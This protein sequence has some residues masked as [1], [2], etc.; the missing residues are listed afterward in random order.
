[1]EYTRNGYNT[2]NIP[3]GK[4]LPELGNAMQGVGY[5]RFKY[6][7]PKPPKGTQHKYY[8]NIYILDCELTIKNSRKKQVVKAMKGH[9]IQYG[10]IDGYF[11]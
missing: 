6:R 1:M 8:F 3:E 2:K 11:E 10:F 7:G 5:G 9:I 4:I